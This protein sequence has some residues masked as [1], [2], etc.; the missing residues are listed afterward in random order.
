MK[1]FMFVGVLFLVLAT[2]SCKTYC[3]RSCVNRY[4]S[5]SP[6]EEIQ[7]YSDVALEDEDMARHN[8]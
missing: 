5:I 1:R 3:G 7:E 6:K 4:S 8:Q 2:T